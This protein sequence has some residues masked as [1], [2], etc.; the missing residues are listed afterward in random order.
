MFLAIDWCIS[1]ILSQPHTYAW[2]FGCLSYTFTDMRLILVKWVTHVKDKFEPTWEEEGK[3]I[4]QIN[5]FECKETFGVIGDL[6]WYQRSLWHFL[7]PSRAMRLTHPTLALY[8]PSHSHA[9]T[10]IFWAI[11]VM[12]I[13][14]GC[15]L[16][17]A[18]FSCS[19]CIISKPH[20]CMS[21]QLS[22]HTPHEPSHNHTP[23]HI[24]LIV[25]HAPSHNH[26]HTRVF[27]V[28]PRV[29][30]VIS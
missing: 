16:F 17:L 21:L 2:L 12:C 4:N 3:D 8:A 19:S 22:I 15:R 9:P 29:T 14:L 10:N 28:F 5:K 13:F 27:S 24:F 6:T 26:M 7:D 20:P 30:R 23:M 25:F 11:Y 1:R 18:V